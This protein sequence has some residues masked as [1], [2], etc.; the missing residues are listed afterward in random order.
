MADRKPKVKGVPPATAAPPVDQKPQ[1]E[2]F[3]EAA[4]EVGATSETLDKAVGK[5][6]PPKLKK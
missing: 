6:A 1:F 5:I 2:R 3:L 4:D